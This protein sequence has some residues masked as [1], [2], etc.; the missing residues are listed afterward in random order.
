MQIEAADM[1]DQLTNAVCRA[2]DLSA[3]TAEQQA[4][5][6]GAYGEGLRQSMAATVL[7]FIPAAVLYLVASLTLKKDMVARP[8]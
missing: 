2:K 4:V 3:L 6:V 7:F 1:G 8:V 5:C